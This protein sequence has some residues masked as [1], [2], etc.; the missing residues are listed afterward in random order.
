MTRPVATGQMKQLA[1]GHI[2]KLAKDVQTTFP[3]M[4]VHQ[5]LTDAA[6]ELD[7]G[8]THSA[9][10]HMHAAIFGLTPLQ[11]RRHGIHDDGGHESAKGFMQRAHR[12]LLLTKDVEDV[13]ASNDSYFAQRRDERDQQAAARSAVPVSPV[14]GQP[15]PQRLSWDRHLALIELAATPHHETAAGREA[16]RKKGHT[17]YGTSYPVP[18]ASYWHKAVQAVGRVAPGKR[19]VLKR[20]LL[21]RARELGI[22]PSGTWVAAANPPGESITLARYGIEDKWIELVGPK[23]YI[24]G[25]IKVGQQEAARANRGFTRA[26]TGS[27][28]ARGEGAWRLPTQ[29]A[30]GGRAAKLGLIGPAP[31]RG[32]LGAFKG[33]FKSLNQPTKPVDWLSGV[34]L[35]DNPAGVQRPERVQ[36]DVRVPPGPEGLAAH[37]RQFHPAMAVADQTRHALE[38]LQG[39]PGH[40]HAFLSQIR[41]RMKAAGKAVKG[42]PDKNAVDWMSGIGMSNER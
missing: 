28:V 17:A 5:H 15:V 27:G 24:H 41:A 6:R 29:A 40:S 3:E 1:T 35:P 33:A 30:T 18:N 7:H 22:N 42:P 25:W 21:K 36:R 13:S 9:Q 16:L 31:S 37:V 4:D 38:H 2:R 34:G 26:V 32:S 23:G 14:N 39:N 12:G 11:V 10:R 19:G 8:R 20:F